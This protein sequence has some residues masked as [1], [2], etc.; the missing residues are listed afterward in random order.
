M[1]YDEALVCV[2]DYKVAMQ[3]RPR[4]RRPTDPLDGAWPWRPMASTRCARFKQDERTGRAA[5]DYATQR[6]PTCVGRGVGLRKVR[7][8]TKH[9]FS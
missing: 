7:Q 6:L 1:V 5:L 8:L 9:R 4:K 2:K 3:A